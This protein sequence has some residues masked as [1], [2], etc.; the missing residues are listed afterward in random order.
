MSIQI[1]YIFLFLVFK[2]ISNLFFLRVTGA[3]KGEESFIN[4]KWYVY[5][6]EFKFQ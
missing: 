1:I 2:S 3:L 5:Y 4:S 6:K